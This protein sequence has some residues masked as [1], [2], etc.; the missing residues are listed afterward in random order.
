MV[1][2][3]LW[4][5]LFK[6]GEKG[7]TLYYSEVLEILERKGV[8]LGKGRSAYNKLVKHLHYVCIYA[9]K[10]WKILPGSLIVTKKDKIPSTGYFKFLNQL[11]ACKGKDLSAW[12]REKRRFYEFCR[13]F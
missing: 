13:N 8:T 2:W 5:I 1:E 12:E 11:G 10:N 4:E 3:I 7:K 6:A 9:Y